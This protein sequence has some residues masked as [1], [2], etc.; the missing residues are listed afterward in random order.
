LTRTTDDRSL[1]TALERI[2]EIFRTT[3]IEVGRR[4][5]TRDDLHCRRDEPAGKLKH[6]P[7]RSR[8]S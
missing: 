2:D 4:N 7:P 8:A 1:R 6:D 5:W 3:R